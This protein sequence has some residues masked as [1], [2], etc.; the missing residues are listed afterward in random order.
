MMMSW[1]ATSEPDYFAVRHLGII[2]IQNYQTHQ[3]RNYLGSLPMPEKVTT[4]GALGAAAPRVAAMA[5]VVLGYQL[6]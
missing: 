1:N 3:F 5:A 2:N 6:F 4:S